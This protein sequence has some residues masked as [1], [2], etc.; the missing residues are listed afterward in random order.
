MGFVSPD[1]MMET[2]APELYSALFKRLVVKEAYVRQYQ[3]HKDILFE[4]AEWSPCTR[5]MPD[6]AAR[7]DL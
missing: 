3:K 6:P 2:H 5:L 7:M 1:F 4:P